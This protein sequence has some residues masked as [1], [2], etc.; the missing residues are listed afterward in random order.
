MTCTVAAISVDDSGRRPFP[1]EG[2]S[3]SVP[4]DLVTPTP[5]L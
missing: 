1:G 4:L 2:T 3:A 5:S